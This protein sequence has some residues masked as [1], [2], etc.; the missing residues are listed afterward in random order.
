MSQIWQ[1]ISGTL[2]QQ[3]PAYT[4]HFDVRGSKKAILHLVIE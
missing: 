3:T 2:D 1:I 4:T